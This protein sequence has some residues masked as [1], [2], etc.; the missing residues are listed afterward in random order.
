MVGSPTPEEIYGSPRAIREVIRAR[1]RNLIHK[2]RRSLPLAQRRYKRSHDAR[3]RPVNK[4]I[5]AG[6]WVFVNGHA[7]TK[8]KLGTRAAGT[9]KVLAIGEG[10]FSLDIGGY[11]E[12]VSSDH[13]TAAPGPPV[14]PRTLLHNIG[15]PKDVVV[16]EGHQ[17]TGKEFVWEAFVGHEV[18]DDGT[19][20]WWTR[21]W[22]YHP[23]EDSLEFASRYDLRKV[24]QYMRR[25]GLRL[26]ETGL[27]VDFLA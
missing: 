13:V 23:E 15:V 7:R 4:D 24:H 5:Q 2:V 14:D 25:A 12:T 17:H 18:A 21:W 1:L 6:D 16:P 19:L 11:P 3:V 8:H 22:G 20:R 26:E 10:S 27:V 9:Y